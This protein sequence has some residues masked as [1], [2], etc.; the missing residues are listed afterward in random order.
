MPRPPAGVALRGPPCTTMADE[1]KLELKLTGSQVAVA[2]RRVLVKWLVA[3]A[4]LDSRN[5]LRAIH[6]ICLARRDT[7]D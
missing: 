4:G 6:A 3:G 7:R 5:N 2:A 1:S